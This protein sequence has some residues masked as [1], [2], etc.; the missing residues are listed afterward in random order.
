VTRGRRWQR[1][2]WLR[3]VQLACGMRRHPWSERELDLGM[4]LPGYR[5]PCLWICGRCGLA[6]VRDADE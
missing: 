1:R 6:V 4:A 3:L 2:V 5:N